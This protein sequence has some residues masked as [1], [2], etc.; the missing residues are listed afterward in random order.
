MEKPQLIVITPV[1]NEAWVLEAF[2]THCS[3]WADR[4]I[5]ADQHSTDGSREI[6]AR[7][8]KVTLIDNPTD[9]W[10]E[11]ICRARLLEEACRT[12]GDK[13]I[14]AL[15]A[16]EFLS[17]G[18]QHT[19]GWRRIMESQPNEIFYFRWFN[20]YGDFLHGQV[21]GIGA[22]WAAHYAADINIV[23]EYLALEKHAVHCQRVPCLDGDRCKYT[24]IEDIRF[25]HL[26]NMN[27]QRMRNKLDFYQV[28]NH[29]KNPTKSNPINLYRSY[30]RTIEH[31]APTLDFP[32]RLTTADNRDISSLVRTSDHG[33]HYI[34]EIVAILHRKGC[35]TF[36]TLCIWD[37]PDL[38]A[39]GINFKPPLHIQLLHKYLKTTQRHSNSFPIRIIDKL[40]KKFF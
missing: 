11:N 14:F 19:D 38:R 21:E 3:S 36:Q 32:M 39:A 5:I 13:I 20:L 18:F 16:D 34:D 10:V 40:L 7:F 25:V 37:N 28:V 12:E 30:T 1:R 26:G 8:P 6:A 31:E 9:E 24:P 35:K 22:E 33:Q 4:I 27:R 2:L 17:D 15:D 29:D 23:A